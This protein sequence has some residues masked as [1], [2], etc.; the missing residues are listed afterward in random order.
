[1]VGGILLLI[2]QNEKRAARA[3]QLEKQNEGENFW[4]IAKKHKQWIDWL[5]HLVV[6]SVASLNV[7]DRTIQLGMAKRHHG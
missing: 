4:Q 6:R 5:E 2:L 7:Y 3:R 1:M